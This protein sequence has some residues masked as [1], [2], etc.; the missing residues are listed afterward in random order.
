MAASI[1]TPTAAQAAAPIERQ[2]ICLEVEPG[3]VCLRG[4][5]PQRLRFEVEYGLERGTTANSFLL[6]GGVASGGKL[7]P[8]VLVHPPGASF[9][10]AF[11]E[12]LGR[13]VPADAALKVVVGHVNPNRVALLR[14]LAER[15]PQLMLVASNT[16]AKLLA[17]LWQQR[18]P[19]AASHSASPPS[20]ALSDSTQSDSAQSDST[21][22]G[23]APSSN[24]PSSG[25][26]ASNSPAT[27]ALAS[28]CSP[29][30]API[31]ALPPIDVVK[32][33][34]SRKLA[35]GYQLRLIPTP[36]PRWPGALVAFEERTGLLLSG[37]FFAAHLCTESWAEANR[38]STEED[39]RYFYDC[40]MAPMARQVES[41]VERLEELDI[42]CI[43]PGHG[44]AIAESWRSLLVDY[45]RWGEPQERSR[46]AVALLYASAY[47]NTAAIADALAQGVARTG[48]RVESINCEFAPPDQL[49]EAIGRCNALLIGSPTLG[50][51]APTPIVSALGTV[52]A[53]ADRAKPVGVFG[54][55]GW[56]GEALDLLESKLRDGGFRFAFEPIRVKFSPDAATIKAIE[57][58]GTGLGRQLLSEQRSSQ[59]RASIGGLNE[60][61][62]N[63][64][65][66]ALGRVV[67]SLCVLT[68]ERGEGQGRL[69]G[70]MVASWVSQASF[71][72]PGFTVAVAKDR[73]V[74]SLLHVGDT[75]LL[76]VLAEGRDSGPMKQFL[77]PFA[78]GADRFAGLDLLRSPSGQ[79]ILPEALAWLEARVN[80]RME[81]G[82]H[83]LIYAQVNH[84]GLLDALGT[85][86]VHQR[87]NGS[88]Y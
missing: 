30:E 53:E 83:W 39:R 48:V 45:R 2:V 69:S 12:Q 22:S 3:L 8:P 63:P 36:T 44:P 70:A 49:I 40:L 74:E 59:R 60:S 64:A 62:S 14:Q 9:A 50:G 27:G 88:N 38:S 56:S 47:G 55:F 42:R 68:T 33:E 11:L 79:P 28:D 57:E 34:V 25:T 54:S 37:K 21:K 23:S 84:G 72:P 65:I 61:R 15:W 18:K 6:E 71:T 73:A 80:Q 35:N 16:G 77:K 75:F 66:L 29:A 87:R 5:S 43:A 81:C 7:V 86:A 24:T 26:T 13:L 46:L 78:P 19:V 52:L 31:P 17:E 58:T 20:G 82:D 10:A 1:T 4:L 51:H 41:V 67:G 32:Q 85:T 76:N